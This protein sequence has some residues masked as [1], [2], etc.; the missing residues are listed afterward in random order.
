[1]IPGEYYHIYNR[2]ADKRTIF[3]DDAD[4]RRFIELLYLAN[5]ELSINVRS[6]RRTEVSI[7]DF[8]R[9]SQ[10]VYIGAYCLM[11][12]H[13]HIL[14]MPAQEG[15]IQNFIQKL[16]TAY[17]MYFNKRYE[18]TGTLFQ[19]RFK[20]QLA[21]DDVYL[22]YLYAYIHLN[23]VKLV[24]SNWKESGISDIEKTKTFIRKYGYSSYAD[25]AGVSR[26][27]SCILNVES[28]P[29]YFLSSKDFETNIFDWFKHN[30]QV[31]PV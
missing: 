31:L 26:K 14:L 7:F 11:P 6:V 15:G 1:M 30:K 13:F 28:F 18:R 25:Y 29:E 2:G 16:S 8:D 5:T 9:K 17:S 19:G 4:Y 20:A 12:N 3:M 27:E 23:P 22:K 21:N 10:L 24:Q